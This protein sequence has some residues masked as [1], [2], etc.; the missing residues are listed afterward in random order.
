MQQQQPSPASQQQQRPPFPPGQQ[1]PMRPMNF[2]PGPQQPSGGGFR[3]PMQ[4]GLPRPGFQASATGTPPPQHP[5]LPGT[6]G[7]SVRPGFIPGTPGQQ[8][9]LMRPVAQSPIQSPARPNLGGTPSPVQ[10]HQPIEQA[11][12]SPTSQNA[13]VA[14]AEHHRRK[15]MYPEQI[16]KAYS[17][18]SVPL[19]SPGYPTQQ[20]QQQQYGSPGMA[21][22]QLN[23][24][25]PQF[26][27]SMGTPS[28]GYAQPQQ[29]QA[30]HAQQAAYGQQQPATAYNAYNQDPVSQ[31]SSQFG[32]MNMGVPTAS[33]VSILVKSV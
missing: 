13:N 2:R 18:D 16:T 10:Q 33:A 9:P 14:A 20:Q 17:G 26:I 29:Q 7:G 32:N 23:Q 11:P 28:A 15:R 1:P 12:M 21:S 31:M 3:P 8:R 24:Q 25:Q 30:M 5:G 22:Q 4:P 6:P 27:S 19:A